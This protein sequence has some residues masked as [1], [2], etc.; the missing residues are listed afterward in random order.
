MPINIK[1]RAR[2]TRL[3]SPA[4][5]AWSLINCP[6]TVTPG[7]VTGRLPLMENTVCRIHPPP[8]VAGGRVGVGDV[9][10]LAIITITSTHR[11]SS[12]FRF[13]TVV[14]SLLPY[15]IPNFVN[16]SAMILRPSVSLRAEMLARSD[17][18]NSRLFSGEWLLTLAVAVAPVPR[19]RAATL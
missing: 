16:A 3:G 14:S 10:Q 15:S 13:L 7:A 9:S 5:P 19:A 4:A 12:H 18:S 8:G 17:S 11:N 6:V 1:S 2:A